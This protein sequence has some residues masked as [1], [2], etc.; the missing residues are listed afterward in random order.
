MS[1]HVSDNLNA[2]DHIVS[3]ED[4]NC[5]MQVASHWFT[6]VETIQTSTNASI[7]PKINV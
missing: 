2:I 1:Y 5:R 6:I 3:V 7:T 4:A